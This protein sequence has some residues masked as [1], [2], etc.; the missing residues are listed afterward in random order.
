MSGYTN[1][2]PA[3]AFDLNRKVKEYIDQ[4]NQEGQIDLDERGYPYLLSV[5]RQGPNYVVKIARNNKVE[6][7][8]LNPRKK[9]EPVKSWSDDRFVRRGGKQV[10][11]IDDEQENPRRERAKRTAFEDYDY[12]V[13]QILRG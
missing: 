3:V 7:F 6:S 12:V 9:A 5:D 11:S 8:I 13:D 2:Y 4:L 10:I 1:I